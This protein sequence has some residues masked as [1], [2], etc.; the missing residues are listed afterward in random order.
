MS[1]KAGKLAMARERLQP[2]TTEELAEVTGGMGGPWGGKPPYGPPPQQPCGPNF[3]H[4]H[5]R[6]HHH[7]HHHHHNHPF[8]FGCGFQPPI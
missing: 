8:F 7:H 1:G 3:G 6:H 4:H 5:R 2:L